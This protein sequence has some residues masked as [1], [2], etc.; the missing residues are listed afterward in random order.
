MF[1]QS[2]LSLLL[3]SLIT[4]A[5]VLHFM[6]SILRWWFSR[7]LLWGFIAFGE[8]QIYAVMFGRTSKSRANL[9]FILALAAN[10]LK[11]PLNLFSYYL[12]KLF[13][14]LWLVV[15]TQTGSVLLT[16]AVNANILEFGYGLATYHYRITLFLTFNSEQL[17]FPFTEWQLNA[18][19]SIIE[20]PED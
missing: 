18:E 20:H 5:W 15:F 11:V 12:S 2:L 17:P 8:K 7:F 14:L 3:K 1:N 6:V 9:L 10:C 4:Q 19:P 13:L 16:G